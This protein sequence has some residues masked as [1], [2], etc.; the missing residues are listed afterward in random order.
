MGLLHTHCL[1]ILGIPEPAASM[2]MPS[3]QCRLDCR[4]APYITFCKLALSWQATLQNG[5]LDVSGIIKSH[6][7]AEKRLSNQRSTLRT[8][9]NFDCPTVLQPCEK[10]Q[11]LCIQFKMSIIQ[12][13]SI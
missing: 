2:A 1:L 4:A 11:L 3:S 12:F 9:F 5:P 10:S 7:K 8:Y 13:H 6:C